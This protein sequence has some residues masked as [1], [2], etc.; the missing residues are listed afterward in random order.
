MTTPLQLIEAL[1]ER[2]PDLGVAYT[3][4][5]DG[6]VIASVKGPKADRVIDRIRKNY[7]S[8]FIVEMLS[9]VGQDGNPV[10]LVRIIPVERD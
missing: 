5:E 10:V 2:F 4:T 1:G 6:N 3:A 9:H 7:K 8:R